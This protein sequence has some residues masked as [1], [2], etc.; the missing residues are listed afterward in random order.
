MI[1]IL[2]L[3]SGLS[4]QDAGRSGWRRFGVPSGGAMDRRSMTLANTLLGNSTQAPVLEIVRLGAQVRVMSDT[5]IAL[6]GADFCSIFKAGTARLVLAGEVLV[7]DQRASGLYAYLAV[8][9]GFRAE[10][11]LGSA[12]T[13]LRNGMGCAL[14]RGDRLESLRA[15][16]NITTEGVARRVAIEPTDQ[17]CENR[18]HFELYRGTQYEAFSAATREKFVRSEWTISKRSDRT[19]YR[20]EGNSLAVPASI[21]SEPVLPGSV[22]VPGNG[23]PIITMRDGPT[24]GG[25]AKIAFL[26]A[27]DLDRMAQCAP[28]CLL[29][30]SWLD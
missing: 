16:P 2:S 10:H 3:G 1:E 6:A 20:L 15:T 9:G 17:I 8:P 4:L 28:G 13:D 24:V 21:P 23:Q 22:Q 12:S 26:K 14:R 29:S 30:F 27:D 7:F 19:G 18:A 11:W 5:W 25:Y